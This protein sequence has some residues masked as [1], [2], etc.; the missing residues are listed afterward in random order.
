MKLLRDLVGVT[1][2][3]RYR[4]VSR[5]AGGG[6]GEVYRGHDLLLDRGV[7]IKVLM[8]SLAGD[9]E[10][11]ARFKAEARA[12]AKLNHP[13]VVAVHD[14][15]CEDERTYYMV[16]EYVSGTD[17]RNIIVGRGPLDPHHACEIVAGVCDALQAAHTSGL[18]HRDVK[19]ENV[20]IARDGTVKVADFG[21]AAIADV[22]RTLPGG[23]ILGTLRYLAPEQA[24]GHEATAASDIWAAGALL[25]EL[26]TGAPPHTGTGAELLKRRAEEEVPLPS[27]LEPGITAELDDIVRRACAIDPDQ[28]FFDAGAMASSLRRAAEGLQPRG[29][30][31]IADFFRDLTDEITLPELHPTNFTGRMARRQETAQ[32]R[33]RTLRAAIVALAVVGLAFGG[34]QAGAAVFG[35]KEVDVPALVGL[36]EKA[37]RAAA[38]EAGFEVDVIGRE[39]HPDLEEGRIVSQDPP[40]GVL[41]EGET[42]GLVVSLGPPLVKVPALAGMKLPAAEAELARLKLDVGVITYDFSTEHPDG[43]VI[44]AVALKKRVEEGTAVDLVVSKGPRD[45]PVPDVAGLSAGKAKKE[46]SSAGFE[47]TLVEVYSDEVEAG[48]VVGTTPA[49]GTLAPEAG[50]IELLVSIGPEFAVV[51]MP[52]VRNM[53]VD[54]A[55]LKLEK[56]GLR[57]EVIQSCEGSTVIESDPLP[58]TELRENDT[59]A[60]LVC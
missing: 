55:R 39:R 24:A 46:L 42:I 25:F 16:M 6:M 13:N 35:A 14:W 18:V 21:I 5:I 1:L 47:V 34:W 43:V 58:G 41:L 52:D 38:T 27:G 8:P 26:L 12:A 37:A 28:R 10:L 22:E 57:V 3:D 15:G 60:L 32:G 54:A 29:R 2:S 9:P 59:V 48:L 11:V 33:R 36:S 45:V 23:A 4:V 50:A 44:E 20:L 49:A 53:Q 40:G 56:L 7:A 51:T 17:L 19:P 30:R 31:S